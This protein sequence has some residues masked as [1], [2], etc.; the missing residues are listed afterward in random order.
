MDHLPSI[1]NNLNELT[2]ENAK[3]EL[4]ACNDMTSKFGLELTESDIEDLVECRRKSLKNAGRMEFGNG[5][6]TKLIYAFCDSPY[7]D[8]NNYADTLAELQDSF[9]YYKT[10]SE[11]E[12]T[13]DELIEYMVKV[14]NGRAQG[15]VEY[16]TG[17]SLNNLCRYGEEDFDE[18]DINE[19]GDLF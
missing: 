5:I 9:Y 8:R 14:F 15:S 19:I 17:T 11:D 10:E 4:R 12:Y 1:L 6:M 13:D 2:V 16:L 3:A 7:L 18:N